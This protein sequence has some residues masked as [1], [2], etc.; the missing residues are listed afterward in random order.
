MEEFRPMASAK[1]AKSRKTVKAARPSRKQRNLEK[2]Q[3]PEELMAKLDAATAEH[4]AEMKVLGTKLIAVMKKCNYHPTV[5]LDTLQT[6]LSVG[7]ADTLGKEQGELFDAHIHAYHQDSRM[8]SV[9]QMLGVSLS[10][11]MVDPGTEEEPTATP[12]AVDPSD[13]VAAGT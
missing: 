13:S 5:M 2:V 7:I 1:K 11:L 4:D 10:D 6:L 9:A 12:E 8:L 3:T